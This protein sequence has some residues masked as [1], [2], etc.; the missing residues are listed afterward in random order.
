MTAGGPILDRSLY[1]QSLELSQ[2]LLTDH[3]SELVGSLQPLLA[4]EKRTRAASDAY[5]EAKLAE[6]PM[7][8]LG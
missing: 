7:L 3:E 4:L 8:P 6:N 5:P 2:T 1:E